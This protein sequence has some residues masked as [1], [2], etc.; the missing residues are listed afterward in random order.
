VREHFVCELFPARREK[1]QMPGHAQEQQIFYLRMNGIIS[2]PPPRLCWAKITRFFAIMQEL[3]RLSL[4][5]GGESIYI[6]SIH[7]FG[8]S[9][10]AQKKCA[11]T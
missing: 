5:G 6:I 4:A 8:C 11:N 1:K 2:A 9:F 10:F 3:A 7:F